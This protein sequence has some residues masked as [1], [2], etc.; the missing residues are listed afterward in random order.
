[1]MSTLG[2]KPQHFGGQEAKRQELPV[3]GGTL[4]HQTGSVTSSARCSEVIFM[5]LT[6][7]GDTGTSYQLLSDHENID[8][9]IYYI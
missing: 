6:E 9:M 4:C 3:S 5:G 8:I 2:T 7:L 1:M